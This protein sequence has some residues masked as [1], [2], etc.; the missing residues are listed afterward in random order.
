VFEE[1][2]KAIESNVQP[3]ADRRKLLESVNDM[4]QSKG[5]PTFISKYKAF[6]SSASDHVT[7]LAPFLPGLAQMLG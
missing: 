7:V 2:K 6:M 5:S 3:E 4:E 1:M